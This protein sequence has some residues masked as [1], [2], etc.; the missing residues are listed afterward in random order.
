MLKSQV[1]V[2]L[3]LGSTRGRKTL[4]VAFPGA[5]ELGVAAV[6]PEWS[7]WPWAARPQLWPQRFVLVRGWGL[8]WLDAVCSCHGRMFLLNSLEN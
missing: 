2:S 7:R 4:Q 1:L 3:G 8:L 5:L 6:A